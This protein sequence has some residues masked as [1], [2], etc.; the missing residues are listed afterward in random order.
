MDS[1]RV[2]ISPTA[3]EQLG[4]YVDYIQFTLLNEDAADAVLLDAYETMDDLET[5][6][7]SLKFCN[8]PDLEA[9]GFRK[10]LFRRHD[11]VMIYDIETDFR[12]EDRP[13]G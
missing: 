6:A 11:Y 12:S 2:E 10:I 4:K 3:R 8:D 13:L 5:S 9:Q 7:G 1:Y